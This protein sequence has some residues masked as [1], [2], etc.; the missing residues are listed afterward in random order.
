LT[1]PRILW[2]RIDSTRK[3]PETLITLGERESAGKKI[4]SK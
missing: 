3:R 2:L 1:G 4:R